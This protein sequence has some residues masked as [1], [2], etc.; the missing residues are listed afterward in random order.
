MKLGSDTTNYT[1]YLLAK[2]RQDEPAPS[3]GMGATLLRRHDRV[4]CSVLEILEHQ[5]RTY[6]KVRLDRVVPGAL[7]AQDDG[8][9]FDDDPSGE[10]YVFFKSQAGYWQHVDFNKKRKRWE[11][12]SAHSLRLGERL[13]CPA[14][15]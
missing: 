8:P 5:G 7:P 4:P 1:N 9:T 13:F 14:E 6:V 3:V 12:C 2:P 11:H 10:Q 15:P